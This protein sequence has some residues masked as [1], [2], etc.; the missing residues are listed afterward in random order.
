MPSISSLPSQ[1]KRPHAKAVVRGI[2]RASENLSAELEQQNEN[3]TPSHFE[4]DNFYITA[5]REEHS[6]SSELFAMRKQLP[7]SY[8]KQESSIEN[9]DIFQRSHESSLELGDF[10]WKIT[11][12]LLQPEEVLKEM[13]M[14]KLRLALDTKRTEAIM[15]LSNGTRVYGAL[16][17]SPRHMIMLLAVSMKWPL[18]SVSMAS[19]WSVLKGPNGSVMMIRRS[20]NVDQ[21]K[22]VAEQ[23][24]IPGWDT[25]DSESLQRP[26]DAT[27]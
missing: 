2:V 26:L 9:I 27:Y 1:K 23:N 24:P 13:T 21:R 19:T 3:R 4:N 17:Q 18:P 15:P 20:L 16:Q 5:A 7:P 11:F 25:N 12:P 14:V 22:W 6:F 8:K 10:A